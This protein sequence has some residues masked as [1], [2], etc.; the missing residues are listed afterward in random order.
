MTPD[1]DSKAS[2]RQPRSR[3]LSTESPQTDGDVLKDFL[4]GDAKEPSHRMVY[5]FVTKETETVRESTAGSS[6]NSPL[7]TYQESFL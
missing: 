7:T 2:R 5:N 1:T 4:G 3:F 6:H